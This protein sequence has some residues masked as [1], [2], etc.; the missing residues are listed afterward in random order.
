[1]TRQNLRRKLQQIR[2]NLPAEQQQTAAREVADKL[3]LRLNHLQPE[4]TTVAVYKSFD[5]E[6]PTAPVIEKLWQLGFNTVLPVLHP[7]LK[8][9]CCFYAILLIPQ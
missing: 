3:Q 1:M 9:I 7:L 5:G 2:R 6:L 8:V 4:Q